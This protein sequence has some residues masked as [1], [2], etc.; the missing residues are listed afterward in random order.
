MIEVSY[1]WRKKKIGTIYWS[2]MNQLQYYEFLVS[3]EPLSKNYLT[4]NFQW[5]LFWNCTHK[6]KYFVRL[7]P[8]R[9]LQKRDNLH[10]RSVIFFV[11]T[12]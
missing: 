1:I 12:L 9:K 7:N 4:D 8:A 2:T 11:V 3:D 10:L 5:C 6:F